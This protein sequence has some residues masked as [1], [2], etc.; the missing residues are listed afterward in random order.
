MARRS[1]ADEHPAKLSEVHK[2]VLVSVQVA[3][4]AVH[5]CLVRGFLHARR[6]KSLSKHTLF[7]FVRDYFR[8][9]FF[10]V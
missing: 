2:V 4:D 6:V 7:C 5:C 3:E 8:A 10:V 1:E 9:I